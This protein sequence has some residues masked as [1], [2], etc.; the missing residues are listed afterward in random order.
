MSQPTAHPTNH[1]A[2]SPAHGVAHILP[3]KTLLI[4]FGSLVV[5]TVLTV[6]ATLVNLG[7]YNLY[8]ALVIAAAKGTLVILYFMHLRY[9]RPFNLV[10]FLTCLVFVVLFIGG[11]LTDT[12]TYQHQVQ[13]GQGG[14]MKNF[15]TPFGTTA[16]AK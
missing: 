9:D 7:E 2:P 15:H 8:L 4:V 14:A 13:P 6:A 12:L 1:D 3:L 10:V 5:L 16:P 11:T